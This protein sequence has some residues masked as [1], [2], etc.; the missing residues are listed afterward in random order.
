MRTWLRW[1]WAVHLC[2]D[3]A[4]CISCV[5]NL[6]SLH[7][8]NCARFSIASTQYSK[9]VSLTL[10]AVTLPNTA[11]IY[12]STLCIF[13]LCYI[14]MVILTE[15][16]RI[17]IKDMIIR[18]HLKSKSS[19]EILNTIFDTLNGTWEVS[20]CRWGYLEANVEVECGMQ[21]IYW[22]SKSV[23]RRERKQ[24]WA[25]GEI[26]ARCRQSHTWTNPTRSSAAHV[27]Q[28]S[29]VVSGWNG[30]AFLALPQPVLRCACLRERHLCSWGKLFRSWQL[31]AVCWY[32]GHNSFLQE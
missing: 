31:E 5:S 10:Q 24:N 11:R 21:N 17:Y 9:P 26:T 12:S 14:C 19:L 23:A 29:C 7:Q 6:P 4:S 15:L 22:G 25:E 16:W 1:Q 28:Q 13:I 20:C 18:C 32:L 3:C 27:A 2:H 30:W 8:G